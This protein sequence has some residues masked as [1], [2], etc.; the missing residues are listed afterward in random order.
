[1]SLFNNLFNVI[2]LE[3]CLI[4]KRTVSKTLVM[5]TF[6]IADGLKNRNLLLSFESENRT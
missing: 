5:L 1:M 2:E 6:G 3:A 4:V